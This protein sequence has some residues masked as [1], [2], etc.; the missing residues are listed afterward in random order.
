MKLKTEMK[1]DVSG[2]WYAHDPD[3]YQTEGAVAH[4]A[5]AAHAL[6]RVLDVWEHACPDEVN[7]VHQRAD[8]LMREWTE[9]VG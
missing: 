4:D 8:E 6:M 5:M 1:Q 2:A 3:P 7:D 9:G